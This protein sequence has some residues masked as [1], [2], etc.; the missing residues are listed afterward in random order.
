MKVR[1]KFEK[2]I[3]EYLTSSKSFKLTNI[4]FAKMHSQKQESKVK[5]RVKNLL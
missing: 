3:H 1:W 5:V 4:Q 2:E